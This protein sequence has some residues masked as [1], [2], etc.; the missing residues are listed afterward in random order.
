VGARA[1]A[2]DAA[3]GL[4]GPEDPVD[5]VGVT[6]IADLDAFYLEH[7]RCGELDSAVDGDRVWMACTCGAMI[8]RRVNDD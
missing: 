5:K 1:L 2:R 8:S 4:V 6:L 3:R 7:E